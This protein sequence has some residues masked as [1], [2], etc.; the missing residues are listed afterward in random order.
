MLTLERLSFLALRDCVGAF[1]T[2]LCCPHLSLALLSLSC[3]ALVP[4]IVDPSPLFG[5]V[6]DEVVISSAAFLVVFWP[7]QLRWVHFVR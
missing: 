4:R 3:Y 1:A 6:Y 7:Y 5:F 2:S